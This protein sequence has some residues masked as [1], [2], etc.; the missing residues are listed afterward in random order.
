MQRLLQ[1]YKKWCGQEPAEIEQI[2]KSGSNRHYSRLTAHTGSSVIGVINHDTEENRCFISLSRHFSER[3]LPVPEIL[4]VSED[5]SCYLQT[6][7]GRRSLYDAL[8]A[9]RES[10]GCYSERETALVA[11][12]IRLLPHFQVEGADGLDEQSLL[13][14]SVFNEQAAMFDLNYFKYCFL[15][16]TDLAFNEVSMQA[17]F[18][19]FASDLVSVAG[20]PADYSG[21]PVKTFLYRDFQ[22]RNVMLRQA[23]DS[24]CFIDFQGGLIGPLQYDLASFLWQASARYPQKL[25]EAMIGEYLTE[26]HQI[27]SFDEDVFRSKLHLFVLFRILQVLGTYG[28]RGYFERKPYFL[29]SIP[30]AIQNLRRQLLD[31]VCISYPYL[32][33]VL[34]RMVDLPQFQIPD[35]VSPVM[36]IGN[37]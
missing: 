27:C 20:M 4:A 18:D 22:A 29:N 6:D 37:T 30:P 35:I 33:E 7:L 31:G 28:L 2:P 15:K 25:R 34:Q 5:G 26:L 36:N 16:T 9:G 3:H 32:E 24:P 23:D 19:R 10:A 8:K 11:S 12:A 17:D 14:P 1:L 13:S 21:Q